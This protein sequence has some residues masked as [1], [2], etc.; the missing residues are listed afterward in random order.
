MINEKSLVVP[1]FK[2]LAFLL[3]DSSDDQIDNGKQA[4]N[5]RHQLHGNNNSSDVHLISVLLLFR[6]QVFRLR[7]W[8][9]WL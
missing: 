5:E 1:F 9:P 4:D 8:S 2:M 7:L 6:R 3:S